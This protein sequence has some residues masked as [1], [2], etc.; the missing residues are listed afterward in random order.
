M[1]T[2]VQMCARR[3]EWEDYDWR[4]IIANDAWTDTAAAA[5]CRHLRLP[6]SGT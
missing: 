4:Y 5:T 6:D 1:D 3:G 2:L